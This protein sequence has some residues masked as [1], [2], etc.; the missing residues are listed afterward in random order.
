[1]KDFNRITVTGNL[2]RDVEEKM[3]AEGD[4]VTHFTVAVNSYNDKVSFLNVA[5]FRKLAEIASQYLSKGKKV[6]VSGRLEISSW[7]KD[8][9]KKYKTEIIADEIQI[10][11]PRDYAPEP[12]SKSAFVQP[13]PN[14]PK[15]TQD[16]AEFEGMPEAFGEIPF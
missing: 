12:T 5:A 13:P 16:Q 6:L 4:R 15:P 10:L 7:T 8:G 1:M 2:T 14:N 11:T 9:E 3:T